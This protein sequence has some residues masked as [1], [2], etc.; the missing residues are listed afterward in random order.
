MSINS[1]IE[2]TASL[3]LYAI[4]RSKMPLEEKQR[5]SKTILSCKEATNGLTM[6]EKVQKMSENDFD[7]AV[8]SNFDKLETLEER[9]RLNSKIDDLKG[10]METQT[11][12]MEDNQTTII[13]EVKKLSEKMDRKFDNVDK[14]FDNVDKKFEVI[15]QNLDANNQTTAELKGKMS[16]IETSNKNNNPKKFWEK[17]LV[18][19]EKCAWQIVAIIAI[20]VAGIVAAPGIADLFKALIEKI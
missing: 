11:Q 18:T 5:R 8:T 16:E 14:K 7:T 2:Q 19:I 3:L 17:L 13:D 9:D 4:E 20:I 1:D 10:E 6:E 15:T 12:R